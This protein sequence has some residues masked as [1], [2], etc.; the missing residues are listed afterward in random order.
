MANPILSIPLFLCPQPVSSYALF[1]PLGSPF[2]QNSP[3][4]VRRINWRNLNLEPPQEWIVLKP[5]SDFD[6][7]IQ[8][9][10]T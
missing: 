2:L 5:F 3:L 7:L 9:I 10:H 8:S 1:Q 6:V 4:Q